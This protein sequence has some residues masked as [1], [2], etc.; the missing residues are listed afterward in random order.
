MLEY[1]Q[2]LNNNRHRHMRTYTDTKLWSLKSFLKLAT[3]PLLIQDT[4]MN[5]KPDNSEL[6]GST[7][8]LS[9]F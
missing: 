6:E 5:S 4:L 9:S 8:V 2:F 7:C 3:Q 1:K